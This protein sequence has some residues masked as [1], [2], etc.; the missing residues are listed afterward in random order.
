MR[1]LFELLLRLYPDGIR[2]V[3]SA[4]MCAVFGQAAVER[5]EKGRLAFYRF[6][7]AEMFGLLFGAAAAR[8]RRG[9]GDTWLDLRHM[10]PPNIS[11]EQYTAAVDE[12]LA[13]QKWVEFNRRRMEGA[14]FRQNFVE[15][16]FYSQ[17]DYIARAHLQQVR[18]KYRI[19][20]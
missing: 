4:E 16:R 17:E 14:I 19:E 18:R 13:A 3:F 15:A 9:E 1:K 5:R 8:M 12:V 7:L 2:T 6:V 10:R 11:R 20:D